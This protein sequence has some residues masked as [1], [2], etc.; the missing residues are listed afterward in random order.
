MTNKLPP[1]P[2]EQHENLY[3]QSNWGYIGND[4]EVIKIHVYN[5]TK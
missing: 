2:E 5:L 1:V 3:K 4:S